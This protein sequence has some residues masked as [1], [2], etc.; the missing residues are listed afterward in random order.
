KE[1]LECRNVE[2]KIKGN[3][4]YKH[5]YYSKDGS[6]VNI[7][8]ANQKVEYKTY[9]YASEVINDTKAA[10]NDEGK[11]FEH[12]SSLVDADKT[13][14]ISLFINSNAREQCNPGWCYQN[15][16]NSD[17]NSKRMLEWRWKAREGRDCDE[18]I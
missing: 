14:N 17:K 10:S 11:A 16:K 3:E 2:T 6:Q 18:K 13:D 8:M 7:N 1:G 15:S 5:G 9:N 4:M 12:Y